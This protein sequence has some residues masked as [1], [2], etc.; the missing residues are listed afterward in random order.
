MTFFF[1]ILCVNNGGLDAGMTYDKI[2]ELFSAYGTVE[3]IV[4]LSQ[5]P[6]CFVCFS[7]VCEAEMAYNILN[8][9]QIEG[10]LHSQQ[11]RFYISFVNQGM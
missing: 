3:E 4:M 2:K 6:Y 10:S 1:K 5:K 9:C 7:N 8:G 11:S